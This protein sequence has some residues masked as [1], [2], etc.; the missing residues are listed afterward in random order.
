MEKDFLYLNTILNNGSYTKAAKELM[1]SQPALSLFV[2]NLENEFSIKVFYKKGNKLNLTKEGELIYTY[3][4]NKSNLLNNFKNELSSIDELHTGEL[5]IG[6]TT[7]FIDAYMSRVVTKYKSKYPGI[8]ITIINGEV[9]NLIKLTEDNKLDFFLTSPIPSFLSKNIECKSLFSTK[10]LL[11]V[12]QE[13]EINNKLNAYQIEPYQTNIENKKLDSLKYFSENTFIKLSSNKNLG[14][15][16]ESA[17]REFEFV[18]KSVINVSQ[19]ST[20]FSLCCAGAGICL[21]AESDIYYGN[22]NCHPK[23]YYLNNEIFNRKMSIAY[24]KDK[25]ESLAASEFIS[26]LEDVEI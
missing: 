8:N 10:V 11:C 23:Y 2:K 19:S 6:G 20:A 22:Y 15:M 25:K 12:P 4:K 9:P 26:L 21:M 5:R 16:M 24:L 13:Y 1:I 18:P 17:F 7:I 14:S 3:L